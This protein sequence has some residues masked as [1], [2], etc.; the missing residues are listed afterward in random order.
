MYKVWRKLL[1]KHHFGSDIIES[2]TRMIFILGL[3]FF[4][5]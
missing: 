2:L 5:L 4:C 1:P 3:F